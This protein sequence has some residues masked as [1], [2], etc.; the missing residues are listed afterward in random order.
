MTKASP[1]STERRPYVR[2]E[3]K[4]FGTIAALTASNAIGGKNDGSTMG[5]D[6]SVL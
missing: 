5:A 1:P 4:E 3:L 2:P 6:K